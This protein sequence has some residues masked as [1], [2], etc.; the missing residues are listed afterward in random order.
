MMLR[1]KQFHLGLALTNYL[2]RTYLRWVLGDCA[3]IV[4]DADTGRK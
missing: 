4:S 1:G 3:R 2:D